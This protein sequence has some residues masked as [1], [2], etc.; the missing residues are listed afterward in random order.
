MAEPVVVTVSTVLD[1]PDSG[2]PAGKKSEAGSKSPGQYY[3]NIYV[4]VCSIVGIAG[5]L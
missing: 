1:E 4:H 3:N 5:Q 2:G